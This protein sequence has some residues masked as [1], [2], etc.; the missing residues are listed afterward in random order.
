MTILQ[1]LTSYAGRMSRYDFWLKGVLPLS[2]ASSL[3]GV[4]AFLLDSRP[5]SLTAGWFPLVVTMSYWFTLPLWIKRLHDRNRSAWFLLILLIPIIGNVW[6]LCEIGLFRGTTGAN[7]FGKDPLQRDDGTL[8]N[9]PDDSSAFH[10]KPFILLV[11]NVLLAISL[12]VLVVAVVPAC[13]DVFRDLLEGMSL[14][15]LTQYVLNAVWFFRW[16]CDGSVGGCVLGFWGWMSLRAYYAIRSGR[17]SKGNWRW[18]WSSIILVVILDV[19]IGFGLSLP[20]AAMR[21]E[22]KVGQGIYENNRASTQS[23]SFPS[24]GH[25][26]RLGLT[27]IS[28]C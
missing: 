28:F 24:F 5:I 13:V 3:I 4:V 17:A 16:L 6:F 8:M 7:R 2:I 1:A 19:L 9:M 25:V 23:P 18:L 10:L 15:I 11:F 14:P 21:T 27:E 26:G 12:I 22:R 20:F